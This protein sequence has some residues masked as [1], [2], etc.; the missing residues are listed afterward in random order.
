M[1]NY[2][3]SWK[4]GWKW[5]LKSANPLAFI[6]TFWL[7]YVLGYDGESCYYCGKRYFLWWCNDDKLWE[8]V[9]G[10]SGLCCPDCFDKRASKLEITLRWSPVELAP[11]KLKALET[12][13]D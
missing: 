10:K 13:S 12:D 9:A 4:Y 2:S 6:R 7:A 5:A 1:S 11:N 3:Y 8:K